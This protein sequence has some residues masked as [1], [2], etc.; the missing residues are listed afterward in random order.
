LSPEKLRATKVQPEHVQLARRRRT[1]EGGAGRGI[2]Q[3]PPQLREQLADALAREVLVRDADRAR[4][5]ALADRYDERPHALLEKAVPA[6]LRVR[7]A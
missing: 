4:R 7:R 5:P 2:A 6:E 1:H 3:R